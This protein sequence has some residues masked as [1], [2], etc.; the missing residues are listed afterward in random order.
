MA[1]IPLQ[2]GSSGR[3]IL[4]FLSEGL[5]TQVLNLLPEEERKMLQQQLEIIVNI[6]YSINEEEITKNVAALSAPVYC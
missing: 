3:V 1:I 4:A 5:Q 6:R 2:L